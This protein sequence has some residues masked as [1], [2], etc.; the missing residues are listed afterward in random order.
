MIGTII[1]TTIEPEVKPALGL[2]TEPELTT[3][4][5]TIAQLARHQAQKHP[6]T[7]L[8]RLNLGQP[9]TDDERTLYRQLSSFYPSRQNLNAPRTPE[10]IARNLSRGSLNP[11]E[12]VKIR[13]RFS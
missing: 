3:A 6:R 1:G 13:G 8:P 12:S 5:T 11:C 2:R 10:A 7:K 4:A 9:T